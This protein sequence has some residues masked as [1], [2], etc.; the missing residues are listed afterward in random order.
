MQVPLEI[1]FRNA[2]Q[3]Q[4]VKDH[5]VEKVTKLEQFSSHII[6]CHVVVDHENN[7]HKS[8]TLYSTH[9]TMNIP[10]KE[11]AATHSSQE[12]MYVAIKDAFNKILKQLETAS[13][14]Y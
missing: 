12:N 2:P 5:I 10:G 3:S 8:G 6:S 7:N 4:A 14:K 1:T 11:L 13:Q 9:I